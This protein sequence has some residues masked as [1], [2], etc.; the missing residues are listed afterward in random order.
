MILFI[1]KACCG[2]F[3]LA[4]STVTDVFLVIALD[5]G[6]YVGRVG[7]HQNCKEYD[8]VYLI[9]RLYMVLLQFYSKNVE[10]ERYSLRSV[11]SP[12]VIII[13]RFSHAYKR[14]SVVDAPSR[15]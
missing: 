3:E 1:N 11:F 5:N 4:F 14:S 7:Y 15:P 13:H 10:R 8:I 6:K 2:K 9:R 12:A